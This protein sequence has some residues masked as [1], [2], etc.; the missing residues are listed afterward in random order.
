M[1]FKAHTRE[2]RD[3]RQLFFDD[4]VELCEG[5]NLDLH[6]TPAGTVLAV[7]SNQGLIWGKASGRAWKNLDARDRATMLLFWLHH[8]AEQCRRQKE[9]DSKRTAKAA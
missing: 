3:V 9:R 7:R 1:G 5:P 6:L 2:T 4:L 8:A